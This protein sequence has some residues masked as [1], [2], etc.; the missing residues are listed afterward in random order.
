MTKGCQAR[1]SLRVRKDSRP[2]LVKLDAL[3]VFY[4]FF[5]GQKSIKSGF[6]AN[7]LAQMFTLIY[8]EVSLEGVSGHGAR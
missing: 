7:N 3:I 2:T 5:A 4:P 8:D 6:S 1:V